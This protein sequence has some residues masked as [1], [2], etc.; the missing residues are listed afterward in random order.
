[1]D[2]ITLNNGVEMP[3]LGFGTYLIPENNF[4]SAICEAYDLGYR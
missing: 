4:E 1:M 2:K 3:R